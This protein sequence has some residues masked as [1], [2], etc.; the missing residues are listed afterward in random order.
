VLFTDRN[1]K[2]AGL[3]EYCRSICYP[4]EHVPC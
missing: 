1:Q 3:A 4:R 2:N